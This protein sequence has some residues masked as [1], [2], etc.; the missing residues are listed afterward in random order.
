MLGED[1]Q[2]EPLAHEVA[3]AGHDHHAIALLARLLLE[4]RGDLAVDRVAQ[5]GQEEAQRARPPDPQAAGRRIRDV[6]Q[7]G[8]RGLDRLAGGRG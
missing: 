6:V 3:L 7:L 8:G 1:P 5:V 2:G 4:R